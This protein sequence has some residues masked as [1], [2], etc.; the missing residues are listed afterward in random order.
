MVHNIL[1]SLGAILI[2]SCGIIH[3]ILTKTIV[4]GFNSITIENKKVI[5]MEWIVEGLTLYFIGIPF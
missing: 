5:L 3:L 1:L 2:I 4:S